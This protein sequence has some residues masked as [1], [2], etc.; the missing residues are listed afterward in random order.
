[1]NKPGSTP[2]I[3]RSSQNAAYSLLGRLLHRATREN[4]PVI[5]WSIRDG[6]ARASLVGLCDAIDPTERWNSYSAWI[7]AVD[8]RPPRPSAEHGDVDLQ[9][10]ELHL[11]AHA[12]HEGISVSV[13]V[14]L[15]DE[16]LDRWPH[17][18]PFAA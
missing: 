8:A 9:Q 16:E 15:T 11:S 13:V 10:R 3:R 4:L 2:D 7:G 6:N 12:T 14:H 5:S 17:G 18:S 1:M